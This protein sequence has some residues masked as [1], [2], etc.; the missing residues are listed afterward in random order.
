MKGQFESIKALA[1]EAV[2]VPK[3]Q[4]QAIG[5]QKKSLYIG[6]PKENSLQEHRVA[7]IPGAVNLLV[8]NGHR[9][10]IETGAGK[11]IGYTDHQYTEAGAEVAYSPEDVYKADI[12]LKVAPASAKEVEMMRQGQNV[13]SALQLSVQPKDSLKSMMDR[14][15]TAI[16]WEHIKDHSNIFPVVRA[17][18]EIAGNT[19]ILIAA[20][21]LSNV[22]QGSGIMF[23]GIS[24]VPPTEVVILGAGT[25]GEFATRAALGWGASVKVFDNSVS[26]LRRLQNDLGTRLFTSIIQP[27]ILRDA[28]K[29]ADVAI[30]AV[31][32]P[33]GRT[34][35]LVTEEMVSQM[36]EGSVLVDVSIDQGGCFETSEITTHTHP[37]VIKHGVIHYGV[38]NI[39]S[40]V[41]KTASHALSN[42]FAPILLNIGEVGGVVDYI[43]RDSGFRNGVYIYQGTLTNQVLGE[44]FHLPY[45]KLELLIPALL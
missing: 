29:T 35:C 16:A 34:P 19:A 7:L 31:R 11:K 23:G 45:K 21:Y 9:I 4:V 17:M 30:G 8:N 15:V 44:A 1:R 40:R 38:P 28:L 33:Y 14:K 42:I 2:M 43:K 10:V 20:E 41:S 39:A 6:I 18:G 12:I 5:Q 27:D 22:H 36:K 32:S 26:K 24:G 37:V 25:V 3:E 13:F